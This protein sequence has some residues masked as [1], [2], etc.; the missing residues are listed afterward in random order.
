MHGELQT[1]T[2]LADGYV[3]RDSQHLVGDRIVVLFE[4]FGADA[5]DQTEVESPLPLFLLAECQK[6]GAES[7]NCDGKDF[8]TLEHCCLLTPRI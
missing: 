5:D 3:R 4:G 6:G 8:V 7:K 1:N 2:E